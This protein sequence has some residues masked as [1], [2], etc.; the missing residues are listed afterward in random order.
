M[1]PTAPGIANG[2]DAAQS[3]HRGHGQARVG[4]GG[5]ASPRG[6]TPLERVIHVARSARCWS[7]QRKRHPGGRRDP[8]TGDRLDA[9]VRGHDHDTASVVR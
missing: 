5:L 7:V 6:L 1:S 3:C 8:E 9:R 4:N 2:C